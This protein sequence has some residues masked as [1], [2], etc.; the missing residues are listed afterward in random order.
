M[1]I[2]GRL[3]RVLL[4][5]AVAV[6]AAVSVLVCWLTFMIATAILFSGSTGSQ[7]AAFVSLFK[8]A[9]LFVA[10]AIP[11]A[12]VVALLNA[13]AGSERFWWRW[14]VG[15]GLVGGSIAVAHPP[16]GYAMIRFAAP[17]FRLIGFT[18]A[19]DF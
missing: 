4:V 1:N 19:P 9:L 15:A 8:P 6:G 13:L 5:S 16:L 17:L 18:L 3:P 14:I 2:E 11:F 10:G 7:H 12:T